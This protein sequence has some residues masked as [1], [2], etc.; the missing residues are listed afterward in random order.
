MRL[1]DDT[2]LVG[3]TVTLALDSESTGDESRQI[4]GGITTADIVAT[5][6]GKTVSWAQPMEIQFAVDSRPAGMTVERFDCS[7]DFFQASAAGT[8]AS[9][10][11]DASGDLDKLALQLGQFCQLGASQ[12][13]G[14]FRSQG[15]WSTAED[16]SYEASAN[17]TVEDFHLAYDNL[18]PWQEQQLVV[19][20]KALGKADG[21]KISRIDAMQATIESGQDF[22]SADLTAPISEI[23]AAT[24]WPIDCRLRGQLGSWLAR[25]RPWVST[26]EWRMSGGVA[27]TA[28]GTVSASSARL[29]PFTVELTDLKAASSSHLIGEPTVRATGT[30][31]MGRPGQPRGAAD[32]G[33]CELGDCPARSGCEH[34][35]GR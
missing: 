8:F 27:A 5:T 2:A 35:D 16:Q 10:S 19:A 6:G 31:G 32:A 3:G 15:S 4:H 30:L 21:M 18:P 11:F 34:L 12:L 7:S 9:G 33:G 14:R 1:R 23:S 25:L 26:G 22:F 20:A 28:S 29:Q 17:V 24:A 13:A